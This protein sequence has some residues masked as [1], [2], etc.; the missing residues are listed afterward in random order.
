MT[1]L[2]T[3]TATHALDRLADGQPGPACREQEPGVLLIYADGA[4]RHTCWCADGDRLTI[5][6]PTLN[7]WTA[8]PLDAGPSSGTGQTSQF[9]VR[10]LAF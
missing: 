1:H 5:G 7:C 3:M 2:T 10:R 4:A 9:A 6:G 8:G